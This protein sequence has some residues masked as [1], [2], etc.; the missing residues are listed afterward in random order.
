MVSTVLFGSNLRYR[1]IALF[2]VLV[3]AVLVLVFGALPDTNLFWRE[4]QNSGHTLLFIPIAIVILLLLRSLAKRFYQKPYKL[5]MVACCV[6]LIIGVMIELIQLM[7]HGDASAM[8]VV[9]DLAGVIVGFGLYARTDFELRSYDLKS[10]TRMRAGIVVLSF[11]VFIASMFPLAFLSATYV[12]RETAFPVVVDLS[13]NWMRPFLQLQNAVINSPKSEE[14]KMEGE[15]Q[16]TRVD[17]KSG[18]FPGVSIIE[19]SPDWLAYVTLTVIVYSKL[20]QSF[21]LV[22]R[23]HDDQHSYT[24]DDRFNV[25]LTVNSGANHF[26]VLL[27]DIKNAPV[28]R[29]MN[30]M[31]MKEITLFSSRPV[32]GL[33][34]YM[35]DIRLE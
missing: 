17:F 27:E 22:L 9:R 33:Y 15:D 25:V 13:A 5:Y 34:F 30:L 6:S 1:F 8:D 23:V 19:V 18:L 3:G 32:E 26:R 11:F 24:Y 14:F 21:D 31:Q 4:L 10:G 35:S 29:K 16:L 12:Q 28:G 20:D 7:I 2:V